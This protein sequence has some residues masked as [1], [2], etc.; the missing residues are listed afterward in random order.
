MKIMKTLST[1]AHL[2]A[3]LA[4][5][6]IAFFA[7]AQTANAQIANTANEVHPIFIGDTVPNI[8]LKNL[9]GSSIS[10]E[11]VTSQKPT[12]L[13]VYRGGWCP[14]C[15]RHLSAVGEIMNEIDSMG[16]NVVAVS[17]DSPERLNESSEELSLDYQLYSDYSG[18]FIQKMGLAF[19]GPKRYSDMLN[20]A[21]GGNN[22]DAVLPVPSLFVVDANG[23]VLFE[24]V[25]PNYRQRMSSELLLNVLSALQTEG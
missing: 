14:Y 8:E 24:Y 20:K 6:V 10:S 19:Y 18:Q 2:P 1:I 11:A 21:A 17:P 9:D 12:V 16:Y 4:F 7:S 13:I 23:V 3:I 22:P 25:V 15:T 5:T